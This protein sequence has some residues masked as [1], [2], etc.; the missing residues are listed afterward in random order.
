MTTIA[1]RALAFLAS[2]DD[3]ALLAF[4][5]D[6]VGTEWGDMDERLPQHW[7][8]VGGATEYF[9]LNPPESSSNPPASESDAES[10]SRQ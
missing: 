3:D 7:R 9:A 4:I 10:P 8:I 5:E 1:Q 2:L 6:T